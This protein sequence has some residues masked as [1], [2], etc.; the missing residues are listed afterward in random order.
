M[1]KNKI[2][3]GVNIDHAATLRQARGGTTAYPDMKEIA[4][5]AI[6]GGAEQITIHLREDRR[7]IQ[8]VDLKELS[9]LCK[10]LNVPLNLEMAADWK[11]VSYARK[12]RPEWCCFVP[13][14]REELTTE[15][16]LNVRRSQDKIYKMVEK[17]QYIGI[18]CSMFIDPDLDQVRASFEVGADA[19]EFHT[20]H[21]VLYQ[22]EKKQKEWKRLVAAANLAN[23]LHMNVHAGHGLDYNTTKEIR[24]LPFLQEVNIGH[25]LICYSLV[26]GL[27]KSVS[28]M[29]QTLK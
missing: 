6:S 22:G 7:H 23:E 18:E 24:K 10:K 14:K 16:G 12:Y 2:R 15:G 25:S 3:L 8:E 17:L 27:K 5:M 20:G 19:V 13:E 9:H 26:D 21:W 4:V 11:M 1:K 29:K 28:K